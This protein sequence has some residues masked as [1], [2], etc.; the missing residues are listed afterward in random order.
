MQAINLSHLKFENCLLLQLD[1][2]VLLME[3]GCTAI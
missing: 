1:I 3:G 2:C